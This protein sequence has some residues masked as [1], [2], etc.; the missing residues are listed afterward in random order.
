M[1][2]FLATSNYKVKI[3]RK[4]FNVVRFAHD[5]TLIEETE[6]G[7]EA[8]LKQVSALLWNKCNV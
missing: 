6:E 4:L 2:V 3:N 7:L 1:N 5:I 8:S